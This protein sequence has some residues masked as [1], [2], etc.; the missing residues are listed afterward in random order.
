V[1]SK[2]LKTFVT[3]EKEELKFAFSLEGRAFPSNSRNFFD[4]IEQH[5][6]FFLRFTK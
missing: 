1:I 3:V 4:S 5:R 2:N 6:N